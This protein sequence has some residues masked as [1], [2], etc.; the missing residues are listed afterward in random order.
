MDKLRNKKRGMRF[1]TVG[2]IA[3][4]LDFGLLFALRNGLGLPVVASNILSTTTAFVFSFSANRKYTF[5]ATAGNLMR[6]MVLFTVVTLFGLWV[7]QSV[8]I[9]LLLPILEPVEVSD[10]L[11]L[12]L[13][14]LVAT[15]VTM[16][17]NYVM[18]TLVVFHHH[19]ETE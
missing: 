5:R 3:T 17:W 1:L 13:A 8:I 2:L 19:D 9:S 14:K 15:S 11:R 16:V 7:I 18:Y 12:L 10:P 4:I 6:Q